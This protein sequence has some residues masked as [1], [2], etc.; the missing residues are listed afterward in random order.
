[1]QRTFEAYFP[2]FSLALT[3]LDSYNDWCEDLASG[4]HSYISHYA[5]PASA[6]A[7]LCEIVAETSARVRALPAGERHAT[8]CAAMVAMHLSRASA[9][10]AEMRPRTLQI[11]SA[12]GRLTR[13][14]LPLA[15]A[16]RAGYL[17]YPNPEG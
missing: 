11:A 5:D 4:A 3:M 6:V 16:W 9:W 10:T 8:L 17:R 2:W 15:R 7:R 1:V 14:L 12:G 13:L